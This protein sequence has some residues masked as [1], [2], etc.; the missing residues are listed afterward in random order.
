MQSGDY[1]VCVIKVSNRL[2]A[3]FAKI[4]LNLVGP[5]APKAVTKS[6]VRLNPELLNPRFNRLFKKLIK[7]FIPLY[8]VIDIGTY[9]TAFDLQ[10]MLHS[11]HSFVF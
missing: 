7:V 4:S 10:L 11:T 2:C 6:A 8:R 3:S 5:R 9:Q 1:C